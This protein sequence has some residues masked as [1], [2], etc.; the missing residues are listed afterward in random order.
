MVYYLPTLLD[1]KTFFEKIYKDKSEQFDPC[2]PTLQH[3]NLKVPL[4]YINYD[5]QS[6]KNIQVIGQLDNKFIV[7]LD[8][9][10]NMLVLFD[11]HAVHERILVEKHFK[12]PIPFSFKLLTLIQLL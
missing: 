11:Q 1:P 12:G 3:K 2:I 8:I 5:H 6:F 4:N 10:S 7:A 9:N